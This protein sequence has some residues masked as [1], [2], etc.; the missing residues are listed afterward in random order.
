MKLEELDADL[1]FR[2]RG[3]KENGREKGKIMENKRIWEEE[4]GRIFS[5]PQ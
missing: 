2:W 5:S 1:L 4:N 3:R